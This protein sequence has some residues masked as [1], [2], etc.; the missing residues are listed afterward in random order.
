MDVL[1][2]AVKYDIRFARLNDVDSVNQHW[3]LILV[4][5]LTETLYEL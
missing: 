4:S 2:S 5:C 3:Y 1:K